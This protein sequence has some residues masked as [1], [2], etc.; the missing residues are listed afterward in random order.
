MSECVEL[1]SYLALA[2][3]IVDCGRI[4]FA[5]IES[6]S[7]K[8]GNGFDVRIV[9]ENRRIDVL[10]VPERIVRIAETKNSNFVRSVRACVE[11]AEFGKTVL[12]E[13]RYSVRRVLIKVPRA[14]VELA[15]VK[16]GKLVVYVARSL[17][18][19]RKPTRVIVVGHEVCNADVRPFGNMEGRLGV[20]IPACREVELRGLI[21]VCRRCDFLFGISDFF[22]KYLPGVVRP[23][24]YLAVN[25]YG[26]RFGSDL[27]RVGRVFD[28]VCN[29]ISS[30][31]GSHQQSRN[32]QLVF[33]G[34]RHGDVAGHVY[35]VGGH[36]RRGGY[37]ERRVL[38]GAHL[39]ALFG[40]V[41]SG[42]GQRNHGSR[43]RDGN[44]ERVGFA[45]RGN[46]N[47]CPAYRF[48]LYFP[49]VRNLD[50]ARGL[51]GYSRRG[52]C[53]GV[54]ARRERGFDSALGADCPFLAEVG[55]VRHGQRFDCRA[56]GNDYAVA[57]V[58]CLDGNR[59]RADC[60]CVKRRAGNGDYVG[61]V[62]RNR[63]SRVREVVVLGAERELDGTVGCAHNP[64]LGERRLI[65]Y[66]HALERRRDGNFYR[67]RRL[68][69]FYGNGCGAAAHSFQI[70][71]VDVDNVGI[72]RLHDDVGVFERVIFGRKGYFQ[73]AR[74]FALHPRRR[75]RVLV[76]DCN[77]QLF[78]LAA[79]CQRKRRNNRRK[80]CSNDK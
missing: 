32:V 57:E 77:R 68:A 45:L 37:R 80:Q 8:S 58:A 9:F 34:I 78:V 43:V 33:V 11:V 64:R 10:I 28:G 6:E 22:L 21:A 23:R 46:S 60:D 59:S 19:C 51:A 2:R 79:A 15:R 75:E 55:L 7:K 29:G 42:T 76:C 12:I 31:F 16:V 66:R 1:G 73:R 39:A 38:H 54:L 4:A 25:G 24:E 69:C 13:N 48:C 41:K 18:D 47:G 44:L 52:I 62:G 50:C 53:R 56:D 35:A 36:C 74:R 71:A 61:I 14:A 20:I 26:Y 3:E 65:G 67:V 49:A 30:D 5:R 17:N 70:K 63:S 72:A 40:H 27:A